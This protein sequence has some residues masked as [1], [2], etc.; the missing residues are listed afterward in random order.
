[1]NGEVVTVLDAGRSCDGFL[2]MTVE[3]DGGTPVEIEAPIALLEGDDSDAAGMPGDPV[4]WGYALTAHKAQGSQW[5]DVLVVDESWCF[6]AAS[7][8]WLYTAITR[9]AERVTIARRLS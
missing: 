2:P 6:R 1:M 7:R 9:A 4:T 5:D 3:A 8:L